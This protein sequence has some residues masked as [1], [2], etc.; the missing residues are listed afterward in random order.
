[1]VDLG[2]GVVDGTGNRAAEQTEL[3]RAQ[4]A[5]QAA[6]ARVAT[7]ETELD[8]LQRQHIEGGDPRLTILW[9]KVRRIADHAGYPSYGDTLAEEQGAIQHDRQYTV[10]FRTTVEVDI[11]IKVTAINTQTAE[12][13]AR[14]LLTPQRIAN[15][16]HADGGDEMTADEFDITKL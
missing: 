5:E 4:K 10:T 6:L 12:D 2:G 16:M 7:L 11:P 13:A 15:T 14:E 9:A 1:M 8:R 3:A